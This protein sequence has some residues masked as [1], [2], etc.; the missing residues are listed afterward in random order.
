MADGM[1]RLSTSAVI[2]IEVARR[3]MLNHP[4]YQA[5]SEGRLARSVLADYAKQYFHHVDAFPRAVSAVHAA[6]PDRAGRRM[7]AENLAE[8]E[9][10][11]AGKTDHASLWLDFA[12]GVGADEADVRAAA[13]NSETQA[14]IDAFRTL[15]A[16]SYGAGLGALY[17]YESQLPAIASTKIAGLDRFYGVTDATAIAFFT[18]HEAADVEHAAVC[19]ALIDDLPAEARADAIAGAAMLA[20]AL[21]GFLSGV[22]RDA[23]LIC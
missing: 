21:L 20:D 23:D 13:L 10:I 16:K 7:L 14:L 5:W 15:S 4:F 3:A 12:A 22:A 18:V 1:N 11:G 8:E 17:A 9:G 2:D 6:C 19:R